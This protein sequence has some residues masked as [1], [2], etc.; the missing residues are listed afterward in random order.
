MAERML[1]VIERVKQMQS[2]RPDVAA[3]TEG[4]E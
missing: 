1:A 3:G 2:S 4:R